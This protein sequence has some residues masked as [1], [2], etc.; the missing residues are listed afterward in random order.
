MYCNKP[1]NVSELLIGKGY[2]ID[3]GVNCGKK[4]TI[5]FTNSFNALSKM[6]KT[7]VNEVI[8]NRL[9]SS[10]AR[11]IAD[12][13]LNNLDIEVGYLNV[14]DAAYDDIFKDFKNYIIPSTIKSIKIKNMR[15]KYFDALK[16]NHKSFDRA[17]LDYIDFL[18][19][20]INLNYFVVPYNGNID[21]TDVNNMILVKANKKL[22]YDDVLKAFN[23]CKQGCDL[24]YKS[25]INTQLTNISEDNIPFI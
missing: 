5:N 2:V 19:N 22:A 3:F 12:T 14:F 16:E 7:E 4:K 9:I 23:A 13:I 8:V 10:M 18:N 20:D 21:E 6:S 17:K 25:G 11:S 15:E 24:I 1:I